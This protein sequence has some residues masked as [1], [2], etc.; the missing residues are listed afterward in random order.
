MALY[1]TLYGLLKEVGHGGRYLGQSEIVV[2]CK[3]FVILQ[4]PLISYLD[5]SGPLVRRWS[6]VG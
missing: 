3:M 5:F 2:S 6:P 4:S 1:K